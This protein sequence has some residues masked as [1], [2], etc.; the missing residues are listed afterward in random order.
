LSKKV[1][2]KVPDALPRAMAP[3]DVKQLLCAI[4]N[5]RNRAMVL[6]LLR[7]GMR[8]GELFALRV[9]CLRVAPSFP[10]GCGEEQMQSPELKDTERTGAR[11]S[12]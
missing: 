3:E 5:T 7:T 12:F 9:D 2:V 11:G 8:I 1:S 6:M 10:L 4:D